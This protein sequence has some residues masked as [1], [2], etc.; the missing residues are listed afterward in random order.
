MVSLWELGKRVPSQKAVFAVRKA[1]DVEESYLDGGFGKTFHNDPAK[2][3][4][5]SRGAPLR[6]RVN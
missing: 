1:F 6:G 3:D 4:K 2:D 5:E